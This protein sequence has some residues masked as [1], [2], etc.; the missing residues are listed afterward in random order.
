MYSTNSLICWVRVYA[1]INESIQI[2]FLGNG[3]DLI[4][5]WSRYY[6][7]SSLDLTSI[8]LKMG[9]TFGKSP[10]RSI[11]REELLQEANLVRCA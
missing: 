1:K 6:G 9:A 10:S 4:S 8:F 2:I 7:G 5:I 3:D 11:T